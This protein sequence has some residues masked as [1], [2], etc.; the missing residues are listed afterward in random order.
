MIDRVKKRGGKI[1]SQSTWSMD[2]RGRICK[3]G[4]MIDANLVLVPT[5]K[6]GMHYVWPQPEYEDLL[7]MLPR[8]ACQVW[9]PRC[10]G[11]ASWRAVTAGRLIKTSGSGQPT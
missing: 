7:S 3:L 2:T 9:G 1:W 10:A 5:W 11:S 6:P 4:A 8:C